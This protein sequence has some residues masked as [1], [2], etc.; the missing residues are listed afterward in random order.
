MEVLWEYG[1]LKA[2]DITKILNQKIGW[3][4][5]TTYTVIKKCIE[6]GFILRSEP[7][8]VCTA[9]ITLDDARKRHIEDLKEKL[10]DNSGLEM[11]HSM[12]TSKELTSDEIQKLYAFIEKEMKEK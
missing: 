5:N 3:N 4:K 12:I 9:N 6:K 8:F 11:V 2:S 1:P 7:D 10:F